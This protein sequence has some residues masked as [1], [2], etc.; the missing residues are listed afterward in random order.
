M[1]MFSLIYYA[2]GLVMLAPLYKKLPVA[3]PTLLVTNLP[4]R[5]LHSLLSA[6]LGL[7]DS[8]YL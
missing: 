1:R 7:S 4:F 8:G 6:Y 3:T 2:L 5:L